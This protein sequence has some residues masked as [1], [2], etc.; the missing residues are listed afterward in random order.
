MELLS[1]AQH[2]LCRQQDQLG[3]HAA[4]YVHDPPHAAGRLHERAQTFSAVPEPGP[5]GG[6][7]P[8]PHAF[9]HSVVSRRCQLGSLCASC[10]PSADKLPAYDTDDASPGGW[11]NRPVADA[12]DFGCLASGLPVGSLP[13][14]DNAVAPSAQSAPE[15]HP[16]AQ[17]GHLLVLPAPS[18]GAE[19]SREGREEA[20]LAPVDTALLVPRP[21]GGQLDALSDSHCGFNTMSTEPLTDVQQEFVAAL[22]DGRDGGETVRSV[23]ETKRDADCV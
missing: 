20:P 10:L 18:R 6:R 2:H 9:F 19:E 4:V 11:H 8:S 13:A 16:E 15:L 3:I 1:H 17:A 23:N 21:A 22:T 7:P 5:Q 14:T 12:A